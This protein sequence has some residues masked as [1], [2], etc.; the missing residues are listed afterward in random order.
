MPHWRR[1]MQGHSAANVI[2]VVAANRDGLEN[3]SPSKEN[4]GQE[5]ALK[6]FGSSFITDELGEIVVQAERE[7]DEV[8]VSTFDTNDV[9]HARLDWGL[10]RDR[11]PECYK[12]LTEK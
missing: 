4:G 5:S 11:R 9:E 6:F 12:V 3:V 8:I 2:P 1:T 7:G 10:F